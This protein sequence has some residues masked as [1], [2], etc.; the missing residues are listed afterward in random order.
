[1]SSS[2]SPVK[3]MNVGLVDTDENAGGRTMNWRGMVMRCGEQ[4]AHTTL[5]HFLFGLQNMF[6]GVIAKLMN[7]NVE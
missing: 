5:P 6:S 4:L 3:S 2:A 7:T 1:M